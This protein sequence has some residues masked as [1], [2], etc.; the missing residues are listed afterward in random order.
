MA[1]IRLI[2]ALIPLTAL[3]TFAGETPNQSVYTSLVLDQCKALPVDP[4]DPLANGS[5]RCTGYAGIDVFVDQSDERTVVSYGKK[6]DDEPAAGQ[7]MPAF[8]RV[9]EKLEWRLDGNG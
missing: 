1:T 5:W 4:E 7:T 9:G 3:P 6:P 8:N 2:L